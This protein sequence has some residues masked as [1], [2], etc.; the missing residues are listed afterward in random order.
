MKYLFNVVCPII[1]IFFIPGYCGYDI[2]K[3][4][5]PKEPSQSK[6]ISEIA[7]QGCEQAGFDVE[8]QLERC[9]WAFQRCVNVN[10]ELQEQLKEKK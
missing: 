3:R 2:Y 9:E 6:C 7:L 8:R 10:E 4:N 5:K 1:L